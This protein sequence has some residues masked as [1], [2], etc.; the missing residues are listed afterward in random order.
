MSTAPLSNDPRRARVPFASGLDAPETGPRSLISIDQGRSSPS[1]GGICPFWSVIG[2][3]GR[4]APSSCC[5]TSSPSGLESGRW[6]RKPTTPCS[7]FGDL[8]SM[9]GSDGARSTDDRSTRCVPV[10]GRGIE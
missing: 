1:L 6:R 2:M 4:K 9:E 10:D 5:W 3:T 7:R 8:T